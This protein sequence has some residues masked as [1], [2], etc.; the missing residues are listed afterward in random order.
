MARVPY[1]SD[2]AASVIPDLPALF[3]EIA[4]LRGSVLNLYR[5]LANQPPALRAFMGMSHYVRDNSSLDPALREL[6]ILATGHS[7]NVPYEKYHHLPLARRAGVSDA[8]LAALPEWRKSPEFSVTERAVLAYA[9]GVARSR[10]V[11]EETF[12][13]LAENLST[14]EI[15]DLSLTLGWYHLC[16]AILGPLRIE[17][18]DQAG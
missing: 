4:G 16:A 6:A 12:R 1:V 8:K 10:A 13:A 17:I 18:E 7:L 2:A 3:A 5:A 15:V 11:D 14:A 9:D